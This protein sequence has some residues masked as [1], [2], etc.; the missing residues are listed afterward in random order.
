MTSLLWDQHT[1]LPLQTDADVD[2]LTRYQRRGGAFVSVNAGY[3]PHRFNDTMALLAHYRTAI[4]AHPELELAATI[5]DV[6]LT[7]KAGTPR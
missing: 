2:P 3:S 7:T 4:Q 1:C 5:D 6:T